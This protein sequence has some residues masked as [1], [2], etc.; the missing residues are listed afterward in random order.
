MKGLLFLFAK[1]YIAGTERSDAI[2]AARRLNSSGILSAIDHL[3][4]NI[5]T[6]EEAEETVTEYLSL[7]DGIKESGVNAVVSLKLTHLGLDI[8][9]ALAETNAAVVI[10]RALQYDNT[11]WFDMES[12]A[13]TQRT[14]DACIRL[15]GRFP[16]IGIAIQSCLKRSEAD[17]KLLISK[18]ASVRLVKGAYKEPPDI[19]FK[20]KK[21]VDK[22]FERL[23]KQLLLSG[24]MTAIATHDEKIINE[25]KRFADEKKIPRSSFEFEMLLGIKRSLQRN[26]AEEGYQVRTYI[27]YGKDWLPYTI[28]RLRERKE[29]IY[30]VVRNLFD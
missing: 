6:K 20:N 3:G 14:M 16:N 7:L 28:R 4:E 22:N 24:N 9:E 19:A 13:Y 18:G 30:F 5:K 15:R 23:M 1:R 25:T 21:D 12:S 10:E 27:P 17:V 2:D 11:V 29:N 26:L 8:S